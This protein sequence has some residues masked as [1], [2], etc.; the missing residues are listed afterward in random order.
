M[1][2]SSQVLSA[3]GTWYLVPVRDTKTGDPRT[4]RIELSS[5]QAEVAVVPRYMHIYF[6]VFCWESRNMLQRFLLECDL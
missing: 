5:S 4:V 3:C 2:E 6:F 1:H